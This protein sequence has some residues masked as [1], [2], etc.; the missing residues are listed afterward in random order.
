[1]DYLG[2]WASKLQGFHY[3]IEHLPGKDN[4]CTE[5]LST[6]IPN[7]SKAGSMA[8]WVPLHLYLKRISPGLELLKYRYVKNSPL[9][10]PGR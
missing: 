6:W 10:V 3:I 2:Q 7:P 8:L 5:M 1:M 4:L 9:P